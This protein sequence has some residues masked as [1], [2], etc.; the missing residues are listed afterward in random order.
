MVINL[1]LLMKV[2]LKVVRYTSNNQPHHMG[3]EERI[4]LFRVNGVIFEFEVN[5][6]EENQ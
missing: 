4:T 6:F 1:G 2:I 5:V 3:L